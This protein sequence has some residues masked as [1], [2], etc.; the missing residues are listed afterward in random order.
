MKP[1]EPPDSHHLSAAQ[2][3]L[4]LNDV[5]EAVAELEKI[6][7]E[8]DSHP[9]VL[10][11]RWQICVKQEKWAE[12]L[13]LA[14]LMLKTAPEHPASWISRAY[15]LRRI[16]G[17]GLKAAQKCLLKGYEKCPWEPVIA[18]NLACYACQL[19]EWEEARTWL[20]MARKVGSPEVIKRMALKDEDLQPL[21]TEIAAG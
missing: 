11:T 2:G 5:A 14:D 6:R 15:S 3:W 9:D 10:E 20:K 12:C 4:A 7:P 17:G 18:F 21:W 19:G 1:L 13:E 16:P 8:L